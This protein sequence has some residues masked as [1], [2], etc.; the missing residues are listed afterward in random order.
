[1]RPTALGMGSAWIG[2][3]NGS[4]VE[5]VE[6][7][8]RAF[9][10][11]INFFDTAPRYQGGKA[12]R[13]LGQ[14]LADLPRDSVYV[15]TKVGV[16]PGEQADFTAQAINRGFEQSL[17]ALG[18]DHVDLLLIHDPP[19]IESAL[20]DALEPML[21]LKEQ[22]LAR[23]IGIGCRPSAFHLRA[24]ETGQMDVVLT[25]SNYTLINQSALGDTIPDAM[26]RGVGLL[27]G[28]PQGM[29]TLTGVEPDQHQHPRAHAI[30]QWCQQHNVNLRDLAL[31]FCLSLPINGCVLFG[32][33]TASEVDQ[34][35]DSATTPIDEATWTAFEQAFDIQRCTRRDQIPTSSVIDSA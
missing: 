10:R 23:H 2:A 13:W 3:R 5:A 26:R 24:M 31:Q 11:G 19:E 15:S 4:E 18:V 16:R 32:P 34:G 21:R 9:E 8:H 7:V 30:W 22:G 35:I 20:A 1:M 27:L 28:S 12:E 33:A 25:F 29:G 14:A 6:A 17:S